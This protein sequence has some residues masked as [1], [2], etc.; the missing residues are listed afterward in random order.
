MTIR[1]AALVPGLTLALILAGC[2]QK[3]SDE[4][5]AS[6]GSEVLPGSISDDMIDLDT[7][8]ASP[9]MAPVKTE[10]RAKTSAK[11][12]DAEEPEDTTAPAPV[13]AEAPADSGDT[14]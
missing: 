2:G 8:T 13:S 5:A 6:T 9:P 1:S 4:K 14:E 3:G 10:A 12:D 11:A 7:S